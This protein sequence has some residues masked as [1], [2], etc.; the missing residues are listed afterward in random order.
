M[1]LLLLLLLCLWPCQLPAAARRR[2]AAAGE[3]QQH[4][5][6]K[7]T[8][9]KLS[10]FAMKDDWSLGQTKVEVH[11]IMR[12]NGPAS[13]E[14]QAQDGS[15]ADTQ[16]LFRPYDAVELVAGL[17]TCKAGDKDQLQQLTKLVSD[18]HGMKLLIVVGLT[19][20]MLSSE[21]KVMGHTVS[22]PTIQQ[23]PSLNVCQ[24]NTR[25]VL[26]GSIA[27]IPRTQSCLWLQDHSI[28]DAKLAT[29]AS[30]PAD[31][32]FGCLAMHCNATGIQQLEQFGNEG[33]GPR[34]TGPH[35]SAGHVRQTK[36]PQSKGLQ[37]KTARWV[38]KNDLK[39]VTF[40]TLMALTAKL[41][42]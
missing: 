42:R 1:L 10:G 31:I 16:P 21:L 4:K 2:T 36:G 19:S 14:Q 29:F 27:A 6:Q 26:L 13:Q 9:E 20:G 23:Y 18:R 25:Q 37:R 12:T 34:H 39:L 22:R 8:L 35:R 15:A 38:E 41:R 28:W 3:Q 40:D 32:H 11:R 17:S 24:Q 30:R 7:W 5:G 33:A